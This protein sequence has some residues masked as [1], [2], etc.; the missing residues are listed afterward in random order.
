MQLTL[1][2]R[3]KIGRFILIDCCL[4]NDD[5]T[6]ANAIANASFKKDKGRGLS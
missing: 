5:K 4:V 6:I 1:W 3:V 2:R